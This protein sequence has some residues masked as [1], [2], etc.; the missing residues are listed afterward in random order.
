MRYLFLIILL[1]RIP[2]I[3]A[4]TISQSIN[5]T[6]ALLL[7]ND[8]VPT[9]ATMNK[10]IDKM[11][12]T[13]GTL[14][15]IVNTKDKALDINNS[16]TFQ[17]N[18]KPDFLKINF[19]GT[20]KINSSIAA[21]FS[22]ENV[23][24]GAAANIMIGYKMTRIKNESAIKDTFIEYAGKISND[25]LKLKIGSMGQV[26]G[27]WLYINPSIEGRKFYH[28]NNIFGVL[29]SQ[30]IKRTVSLWR[31][32]VGYNYWQ[33]NIKN[34]IFLAGTGLSYSYQD[35]FD[36]LDEYSIAD[37]VNSSGNGVNRGISRKLTGYI[38]Q[39]EI[40]HRLG[41]A[42][43]FYIVPVKAPLF[44]LYTGFI[45][46]MQPDQNP[47]SNISLG[48][49]FNKKQNPLSPNLGIIATFRDVSKNN[50]R[51]KSGERFSINLGAKF[52]LAKVFL[53]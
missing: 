28:I 14:S 12:L 53:N 20:A 26:C 18:N 8:I 3:S 31:I 7:D 46:I 16:Y 34:F 32:S 51:L 41:W 36:D 22:N 42:I 6:S 29:D 50:G 49:Y 35:N 30:F 48:F 1:V 5:T 21:L 52:D 4:Q 24:P 44:G 38:G 25:S 10:L 27:H 40:G 47:E 2:F 39:Y 13:P 15:L 17:T 37:Q 11:G 9:E 23:A 33:P 43:D 45:Q 19:T